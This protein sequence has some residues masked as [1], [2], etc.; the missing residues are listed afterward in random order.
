[1]LHRW[2]FL[3]VVIMVPEWRSLRQLAAVLTWGC[4]CA[5]WVD[6]QMDITPCSGGACHHHIATHTCVLGVIGDIHLQRGL[7]VIA[8]LLIR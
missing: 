6:E 3:G 7:R 2:M 5:W 1:M 8:I 4:S